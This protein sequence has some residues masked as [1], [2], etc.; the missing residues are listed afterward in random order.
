MVLRAATRL[1]QR[2]EAMASGNASAFMCSVF[3]RT[4]KLNSAI[5]ATRQSSEAITEEALGL[6]NEHKARQNRPKKRTYRVMGNPIKREKK[7]NWR[8]KA[9]LSVIDEKSFSTF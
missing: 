1:C 9:Y 8:K 3:P 4:K 7:V 5:P 2:V 6:R